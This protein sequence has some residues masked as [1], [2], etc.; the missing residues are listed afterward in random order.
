VANLGDP[1]PVLDGP[2]EEQDLDPDR[3][4]ENPERLAA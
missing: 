2:G 4:A 3:Q 1:F